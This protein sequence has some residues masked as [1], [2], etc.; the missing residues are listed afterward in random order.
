MKVKGWKKAHHPNHN[1]KKAGAAI[2]ISNKIDFRAKNIS[3]ATGG[4]YIMIKGL[5]YQADT[6]MLNVYAP[7]NRASE[8]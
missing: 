6:M 1:Q 7:N 5:I 4:N 3:G 8:Q 2:L